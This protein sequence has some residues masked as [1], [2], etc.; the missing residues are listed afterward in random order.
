MPCG[1]LKI[2]VLLGLSMALIGAPALAD[3][4]VL[5]SSSDANAAGVILRSGE[6]LYVPAGSRLHILNEDGLTQ[7]VVGPARYLSP[8]AATTDGSVLNAFA[9]MFRNRKDPLRLGGVRA[10]PAATCRSVDDNPS[11]APW[12]KIAKTW[13]NGCHREA[14][15]QLDAALN[16]QP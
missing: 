2:T 14:L 5:Q 1:H 11:I 13:D 16:A 9:A 7:L 3:V 4:M 10:E 8:A 12:I 6:A 15:A